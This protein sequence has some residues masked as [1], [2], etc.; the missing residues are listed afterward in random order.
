MTNKKINRI[1][2][3]LAHQEQQIG[4]LSEMVNTQWKEIEALKSR[5]E[6]ANSKLSYL[7][8]KGSG[9]GQSISDIAAQEKPPHY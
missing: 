8:N 6:Q 7:E 5:L 1:E 4:D 9:E 3:M 2:E